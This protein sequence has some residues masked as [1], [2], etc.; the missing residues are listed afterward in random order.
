MTRL[1]PIPIQILERLPMLQNNK[2]VATL[3]ADRIKFPRH[4]ATPGIM[5]QTIISQSLIIRL[6]DSLHDILQRILILH[7]PCLEFITKHVFHFVEKI[8]LRYASLR[9]GEVY[10][11]I[12]DDFGDLHD[13]VVLGDDIVGFLMFDVFDLDEQDHVEVVA[14]LS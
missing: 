12:S 6:I 2:I 5:I 1:I 3:V 10:M 8:L 4:V 9:F 14:D 11:D 13:F 7:F